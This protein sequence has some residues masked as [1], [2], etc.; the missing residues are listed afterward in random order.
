LV[1]RFRRTESAAKEALYNFGQLFGET[2]RPPVPVVSIAHLLFEL[3]VRPSLL[4]GVSERRAALL[5]PSARQILVR[6][7]CNAYQR[8]FG[9]A[10]EIGH[11][12]MHRLL[13]EDRSISKADQ[14]ELEVE[15]NL[16]A[17]ALLMPAD[18]LEETCTDIGLASLDL[19]SLNWLARLFFVSPEALQL[20]LDYLWNY[21]EWHGPPLVLSAP[22]LKN[23]GQPIRRARREVEIGRIVEKWTAQSGLLVGTSTQ[24]SSPVEPTPRL[25]G[26]VGNTRRH[27][28]QS[29]QI[30]RPKVIEFSGPSSEQLQT[31]MHDLE[32]M[33][34]HEYGLAVKIVGS[35]S[36]KDISFGTALFR[37]P[38]NS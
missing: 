1:S 29:G 28:I 21:D 33:L 4:S 8:R 2:I 22:T 31:G 20:R 27:S 5:L 38:G 30:Y 15:A 3:S 32:H 6:T 12:V 14:A 26:T 24:A 34:A 16:F 37:F 18:L 19:S 35:P 11:W 23:A 10:H 17:A 25:K 9:I 13:L 7:A 36:G